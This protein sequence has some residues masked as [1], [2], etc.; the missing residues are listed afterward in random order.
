MQKYE[1]ISELGE[2]KCKKIKISESQKKTK[3]VGCWLLAVWSRFK[4][5]RCLSLSKAKPKASAL[6]QA[7]R[8]LTVD[9][10]LLTKK[11]RDAAKFYEF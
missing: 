5:Q 11:K 9:R 3:A 2:I 10:C 6:R 4:V 8:P 1:K 7:Q